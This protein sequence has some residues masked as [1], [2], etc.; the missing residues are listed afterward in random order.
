MPPLKDETILL[1]DGILKSI[2]IKNVESNIVMKFKSYDR[3]I[4]YPNTRDYDAAFT[5]ITPNSGNEKL[6]VIDPGHGGIDGGAVSAEKTILEKNIVMEMS[7]ILADNLKEMGYAVLNLR[8]EDIFL[9]L[10]ERTDIAN[11]SNADAI[12]SVHINSY[13]AEYVN[14]ATTMYKDSEKLAQSIQ[15]SLIAETGANDMGFV[16]YNNMSILNRAMMDSVIVETG[17]LTNAA[18][19]ARLNTQEYQAKVAAGI[20]A[21]I[22]NYYKGE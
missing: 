2:E 20:A 4:I 14:G 15:A 5:F 1:N 8:E 18:E 19:A 3:I 10:M 11:L 13:D 12:I 21:G 9:G 22:D 17:F 6:I 16:K 7:R